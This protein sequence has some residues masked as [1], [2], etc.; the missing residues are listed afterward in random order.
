[1]PL[2]DQ[3]S[4]SNGNLTISRVSSSSP[5]PSTSSH[6]APSSVSN[7]REFQPSYHIASRPLSPHMHLAH[8]STAS[9]PSSNSPSYQQPTIASA[10]Q[11]MALPPRNPMSATSVASSVAQKR[12]AAS[13]A[14]QEPA[15]KKPRKRRTCAKCARPECPGSQKVLNCRNPCRD[16]GLV[17]CRGRNSKRPNELCHLRDD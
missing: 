16:C 2:L 10:S 11:N 5:I 7:F 6:A 1:M 14:M 15:A 13:L 12:V 3:P 8:Q 4:S 9:R 17:Q